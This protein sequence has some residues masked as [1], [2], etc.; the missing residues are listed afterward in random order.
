LS[1]I[2]WNAGIIKAISG[3]I[4]LEKALM[5]F[6]SKTDSEERKILN[7]Y[8]NIKCS[9]YGQYK[10]FITNFEL[11]LEENGRLNLSVIT[12]TIKK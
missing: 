8:I 4:E 1:I 3:E 6:K 5:D 12:G 10:E 9:K 11:S 7:E 2:A